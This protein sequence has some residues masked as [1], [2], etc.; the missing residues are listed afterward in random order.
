VELQSVSRS[1]APRLLFIP[2]LESDMQRWQLVKKRIFGRSQRL[3]LGYMVFY[4]KTVLLLHF[5]ANKPWHVMTEEHHPLFLPPSDCAKIV[6]HAVHV[7]SRISIMG[8]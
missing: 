4:N 3:Y 1:I 8:K 7:V 2:S 5:I 6:M